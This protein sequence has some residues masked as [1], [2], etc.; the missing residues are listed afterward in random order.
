MFMRRLGFALCWVVLAL[1]VINSPTV[2]AHTTKNL[3]TLLGLLAQG[4]ARFA[5]AF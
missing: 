4:L 1:F 3:F 5:S 2:A